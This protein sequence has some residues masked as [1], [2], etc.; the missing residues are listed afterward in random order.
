MKDKEIAREF[1]ETME[2]EF[3]D[4]FLNS[5]EEVNSKWEMIKEIIIKTSDSILGR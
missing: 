4:T 5:E 2:K 3:K 1:Q